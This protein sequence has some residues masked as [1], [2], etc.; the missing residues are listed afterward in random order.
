[1]NYIPLT[2]APR[3][4][5]PSISRRP[6]LRV[7]LAALL[8]SN[9]FL[10]AWAD[11]S[12]ADHSAEVDLGLV[13][14]PP[15]STEFP[16]D[17]KIFHFDQGLWNRAR[18]AIDKGQKP[19]E[20][21]KTAEPFI[22]V[23]TT[24]AKPPSQEE[25][26]IIN[27]ELPYESG[28][29]ISGRKLIS[30]RLQETRRKSA[31]RAEELGVPKVEHTFDMKQEL[32]VRIKGKV[33][34]KITVNVD[35]DDTKEDKRDISVVYQGDPEEVVQEAAFGDITLSLPS[36]E[37]VSYSKQLFGIRTKLKYKRLQFMAIGSR[38]K[39]VTETKRFNGN[40][41]FER[42]EIPDT[43]YIRSRYYKLH[44]ADAHLPIAVG[45]ER[46][47]IDDRDITNDVS[48]N[49]L[50]VEDYDVNTTTYSGH[51][52]QM[53]G[54]Q[55][56]T[57]D[58]TKGIITF[59]NALAANTVVAVDYT[60]ADG[61]RLSSQ[62]TAGLLKILKN[63]GDQSPREIKT[64][65]SIGRSKVIRDNG[66]GNF[67]LKVVD[68]NNNDTTVGLSNGASL[69]YPQNIDVDFEGGVFNIAPVT[70]NATVVSDTS[71]YT[72]APLHKF[73]FL[74]EYRYRIKTYLIKPNI[75]LGSERVTMNGRLLARDVDYFIDYD[76]GFLTFFNEDQIDETTQLEVTYEYAPFGGQLGQTLVGER[77]EFNVIPNKMDVGSTVLYTFA[78]KPTAV[79]D[80]RSTPNSLMVLEADSQLKSV[81][82]P[83]LPLT[84]NMAGE[85]AQ[86]REN[87]D[88]FG[89][90]LVESME[91]VKQEDQTIMNAQFWQYASN[92][93][94]NSSTSSP[95]GSLIMSPLPSAFH[96]SDENIAIDKINPRV[97][98]PNGETQRVLVLDYNLS[99]SNAPVSIVQ[100]L[101]TSGRDFSQKIFLDIWVQGAGT[102]APRADLIVNAGK[103]NEDADGDGSL[104]TEDLNNDGTL[105]QG[106]DVGVNF[107]DPGP[108]GIRNTL[109]DGGVVPINNTGRIDTEDLDAD[110][111]LSVSE[112]VPRP[113]LFR[114][115]DG[116]TAANNVH[117]I[118]PDIN[119]PIEEN[120]TSLNFDGW[121]LIHIPLDIKPAETVNFQAIKQVRISIVGLDPGAKGT[122]RVGNI[123]FVGNRWE[124]ATS[125]NGSTMT[126]TAINNIDD[127]RYESLLNNSAYN[128]IYKGDS[129]D[130]TR[131][132]ALD[133]IIP[134]LPAGSTTTTRVV[135]GSPHDFSK[136]KGFKFF[137]RAPSGASTGE[138]FFLQLG[139]ETDYFEYAV[140]IDANYQSRGWVLEGAEMV[141]LNNDGTPD[142]FQPIQG[143]ATVRMVGRPNLAS[144]GQIKVGVRNETGVDI[145]NAELWVNEMFV[146]G[147]RLKVGLARRIGADLSWANWGTFGGK[148]REVDRNFQTLTSP[149]TNQDSIDRSGYMTFTRLGF[150]PLSAN[151]SRADTITPA[152]LKTGDSGLVSVLEEGHVQSTNIGSKGEL[153]IP[154]LPRL[155]FGYDRSLSDSNLLLRTDDRNTYTG[156]LSYSVPWKLDM[157][158][159]RFLTLRPLPESVAMTYRRTN[160]FLTF[161][162]QKKRDD[163]AV[164]PDTNTV[165]NA[166][167][168]DVKTIEYTDDWTARMTFTPWNG[169]SLAPNYAY[170]R[171]REER[172][173]TE[174]DLAAAPDFGQARSY[175][176]AL[177][178]SAGATAS[179]RLLRWLEPR[180]SYNITGTETNALPLASTPTA[181]NLKTLDRT[182]NGDASW[183]FNARDLLPNFR[184][185]LSLSIN[186][187]YGLQVGETY[188]NVGAADRRWLQ[189]FWIK[190]SSMSFAN[191]DARRKQ[192]SS[193]RT[194]R[195]STNWNLFDWMRFPRWLQP[196]NTLSMT[197]TYTHSID[198]SETTDTTRDT[199]STTWPDLIFSIRDLEKTY[200][201]SRWMNNSQ[202]NIRTSRRNSETIKTQRTANQDFSADYRFTLFKRYDFFTSYA[203]NSRLDLTYDSTLGEFITSSVGRGYSY[204]YQ[205]GLVF[206][207]WR[208]TP[209]YN[210]KTDSA[211]DGADK[212]TQDLTT[213]NYNLKARFDK[214]YPKGF[215][216][217]FSKKTFGNINRFTLDTNLGLEQKRSTLNVERDNTDT[218]TLNITGE[219]EI[220]RNFR[221]SF[222]TGGSRIKNRV[223]KGDSLMSYEMNSQLII[224]F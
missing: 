117:I 139:S 52:D 80:V 64:F 37:F 181:F 53:F 200:H 2:T 85:I 86:S 70:P 116:M 62:K 217:P 149:I 13:E 25:A 79:P 219:Y 26:G 54:G 5:L 212:T 144:V 170:K 63:D 131:E 15:P 60:A 177:S 100:P 8:V 12:I 133:L 207:V 137:L 213:K 204:S 91:G 151:Y 160:Y 89:R 56:Y 94:V 27:V 162:D 84:M 111:R 214:A 17:S 14:P 148:F 205:V 210:F 182:S 201:L 161:Y 110:G 179:L 74:T 174:S 48:S 167:F 3:E 39:G 171:V 18:N 120:L 128:D 49:S 29:N 22:K 114:L 216:F 77:T 20:P 190:G 95:I 218:Y 47:M 16:A 88:L 104:D 90:A 92:P 168:A 147:A 158:P 58:Y 68:L 163:L 188:E 41:Q 101:S 107:N 108:D 78:P 150:L 118:K 30:I 153:I 105:N 73:S 135:Y 173:F 224:Q 223:Q 65:Y 76:S 59:R 156:S 164:A 125:L 23:S 130:R 75:V 180:V 45:S 169:F 189:S 206:G 192:F 34:R 199:F 166:I 119:Q 154:N 198:H 109:D 31:K 143:P 24:T 142:V 184:P 28:L 193:Q 38:T 72:T 83:F 7:F 57:I 82:I 42:K 10:P 43:A 1:M 67:I 55:D 122:V 209:S 96:V 106:E 155:G 211:H 121:R 87:P 185:T 19:E 127:P 221:L 36:T 4:S 191:A 187:S 112:D 222:G 134:T 159:S 40:T 132:Q 202:A 215:R 194:Y 71:L 195:S 136:H 152:A 113:F 44:F 6:F 176:K 220:S 172:L 115:S 33:G 11:L 69:L 178:Q 124:R 46:V 141:D 129:G 145:H 157:L 175:D 126:V 93:T 208:F 66:R 123:S 186:N 102:G 21:P 146:T 103:F 203:W 61:T 98:N 165:R 183:T 140:K 97:Q 32:Q 99:N 197:G 138:T 81:K 35:F 9:L 196:L 51:F 50:T